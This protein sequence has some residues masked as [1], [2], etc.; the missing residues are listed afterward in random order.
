MKRI[1]S[2]IF[3]LATVVPAIAKEW[4]PLKSG[5]SKT[6]IE[7]VASDIN[8][9]VLKASLPGYYKQSV[10][11]SQGNAF[12]ISTNK[13]APMLI[14]GAPDLGKFAASVIIPDMAKMKVDIA[15][16]SYHEIQNIDIA[17]SKGHLLRNI[18]P[19]DVPYV[20]GEAYNRNEFFPGKLA[21]LN[22]P[23]I[24]RDYRGQPVWIYPFQYNPVTKTLRV[25][26]EI[27]L[28]ISQDVGVGENILV[29]AKELQSVEPEFN[30]IYS[31][32]FSNYGAERYTPVDENG[33]MLIISYGSFMNAMQPLVDWKIRKGIKVTMVSVTTAGGTATAIK[34]YIA[35]F[36]AANPLKYVL[37]VGDAAQVPTLTASG[38]ASDPSYGYLVGSDS[39]PEVFVGRFS[40]ESIADVNT[41]VQRVIDYERFPQAGAPWYAHGIGVASNLGPGDDN[42][43]DWEHERN[44]RTKLLAFTYTGVDELYDGTHGIVDAAGDPGNTDMIN[45]LQNGASILNY[46]GHGS[47]T[48]M[49][50]TGFS[51]SDIPSLTNYHKLPFVCSV[52]CVNGDF[53]TGTCIAETFLRAQVSNQPT[54]AVAT[55]MSSINQY[56]NEPMRAQDEMVDLLVGTYPGNIKRTYGGL[57]ENGCMNMNDV[58]GTTGYDMT[59]TWHIF[60]DPSLCVRTA[61]PDAITATHPPTTPIGTSQISI[62]SNTNGALACLSM[63][64]QILGTGIVAGGNVTVNFP[65]VNSVDTIYVTLT[66]FN[67]IPYEG[68][69]LIVPGS[70]P[71]VIEVTNTV[72]DVTG[73]NNGAPDF[74]ENITLDVTLQNVGTVT[75]NSV[76]AVISTSDANVT[77]TGPSHSFGNIS[78]SGSSTVNNAFAYT[79][80]NN[81][82]DQHVVPFTVTITDNASNTWNA[83]INHTMNAPVLSIG[84]ISVNDVAGNGNGQLDPGETAIFT[85]VNLNNGHSASL[86]ATAVLTTT[87]PNIT[88]NAPASV[89]I[90][91]INPSATV[92]ASF[93]VSMAP[94]M[95]IGSTF[96]LTITTTAGGYSATYTF[97]ITAGD[98]IEDFE[99]GTFTAYP[100]VMAGTLPWTISTTNSFQ[101]TY[102]ARSGVITDDETSEMKVTMNVLGADSVSFYYNVSSE[103]GYDFFRFYIDNTMMGEWS[104]TVAWTYAAYPVPLGVHALRWVYSKDIYLAAGS[105]RVRVDNINFPP[106]NFITGVTAAA[107]VASTELSIYPNPADDVLNIAYHLDEGGFTSLQVFNSIGQEVK[108]LSRNENQSAGDHHA[109]I[110]TSGLDGGFYFVKLTTE[111]GNKIQ[112]FI[113]R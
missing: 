73:N 21:E 22:S 86:A 111:N 69:V 65:A 113:V 109:A 56:W 31:N 98:Q 52:G 107:P 54:G 47:Q 10:T 103:S 70:G 14:K 40:A 63:N 1:Y 24:L 8:T 94:S 80:A 87:D 49:V 9:T 108:S 74:S 60:G 18:N 33:E 39:Y 82:A 78:S 55:F 44:I 75:A 37:L 81:V 45:S 85:I 99:T 66:A 29:R 89:N 97:V 96:P 30:E 106:M 32:L 34:N 41:Q 90:G 57:C 84:T 76:N 46:T 71:Y 26:D 48:S 3:I 27:V 13:S 101:G 51:V 28:K 67:K 59:N 102:N 50:T 83:Y 91:A 72:V 68:M 11:T 93:S 38:G 110:N 100:W 23:Y 64:G 43:M 5:S 25:Y 7:L 112:K 16:S 15:S 53:T 17:P 92:N 58:Y 4:V 79:V 36:Y 2:L 6:G 19:S 20:Y 88:V 12:V 95:Q 105:D 42:E 61:A 62:T 35:N 104:G 77:I